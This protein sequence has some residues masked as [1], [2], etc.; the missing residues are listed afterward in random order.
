MPFDH[1]RFQKKK[2]RAFDYAVLAE[3][4]P[5]LRN[6]CQLV[7]GSF[8][9]ATSQRQLTVTVPWTAPVSQ[10][11]LIF[12]G[13]A[14]EY[15]VCQVDR[16]EPKWVSL[17]SIVRSSELHYLKFMYKPPFSPPEEAPGYDLPDNLATQKLRRRLRSVAEEHK[18]AIIEKYTRP[19]LFGIEQGFKVI[20]FSESV[21]EWVAEMFSDKTRKCKITASPSD[22]FSYDRWL[23]SFE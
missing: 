7:L 1:Q 2:Q 18:Q 4:Y 8:K 17:S 16:E 14:T 12:L 20:Y 9:S 19:I 11:I 22:G 13:N 23:V 15:F 3:S 21:P 6:L 5:E 10:N